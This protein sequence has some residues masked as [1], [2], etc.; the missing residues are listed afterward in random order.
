MLREC[1]IAPF[2]PPLALRSLVFFFS[3]TRG[4]YRPF[5]ETL[6]EVKTIRLLGPNNNL[7]K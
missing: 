6:I 1:A 2:R 7:L 5:R 4:R 3:P